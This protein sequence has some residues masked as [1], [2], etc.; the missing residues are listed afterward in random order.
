[1]RDALNA[2]GRPI[3]F[4]LCSWGTSNVWEWGMSIGNSWRTSWDID[5]QFKKFLYNL[6]R[7]VGLAKY[8]GPGGWND[9]DML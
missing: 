9:P 3:F 1:M 8:A 2:T 4:S 5:W 7:Q 6:D